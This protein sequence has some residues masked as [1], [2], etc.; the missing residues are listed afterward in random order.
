MKG[1]LVNKK[2]LYGF[3]NHKNY[4]FIKLV[5][6]NT[7]IFNKVKALWYTT[8]KDFRKRKLKPCGWKG[9][10]LY[11]AKLPPLLRYFHIKDI[12]PSGW[13]SYTEDDIMDSSGDV[14]TCCDYEHWIDHN[15]IQ[16][17]RKKE[18]GTFKDM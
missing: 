16:P 13:V 11:E 9:T 8:D 4:Q 14:E 5:F 10:Q 3:D 17:E 15:D 2:K 18:D 7:N 12:S 1:K 6:K